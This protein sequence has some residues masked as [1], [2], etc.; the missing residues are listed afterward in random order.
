MI[1]AVFESLPQTLLQA[2]LVLSLAKAGLNWQTPIIIVSFAISFFRLMI[3]VS[4]K[5]LTM[6]QRDSPLTLTQAGGVHM[7][8]LADAVSR[9]FAFAVFFLY[10]SSGVIALVI[11][12]YIVI[13]LLLL[14][15][16][17][18]SRRQSLQVSIGELSTRLVVGLL[19]SM[20]LT[21][22]RSERWRVFAFSSLASVILTLAVAT[23]D[24]EA[25]GFVLTAVLGAVLVKIVMFF[26]V[27]VQFPD[28]DVGIT[29]G[30][31]VL[32]PTDANSWSDEYWR[33]FVGTKRKLMYVAW[34]ACM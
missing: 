6:F 30:S 21:Q 25:Q 9:S 16:P 24:I 8:F 31:L 23:G 20:P 28:A 32:S 34:L 33:S 17:E 4:G 3:T 12:V 22:R 19:V 11:I 1:E 7:Y 27:I 13:E 26:G 14:L 2:Y 5:L 18:R 29:L 10:S 15:V